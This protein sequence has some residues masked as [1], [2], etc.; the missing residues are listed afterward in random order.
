[1][2][3]QSIL[4][5]LVPP[6]FLLALLAAGLG[7]FDPTPGEAY[8]YTNFRGEAVMINNRGLYQFDTVSS[9]AQMQG[10]DLVT[11]VVALPLLAVSAW[12]AFRG[13]LRGQL[14]LT[15][16]I[17][18]ILYTYLSMSMLT[19]FNPLFLVY[20]ALF[21]LSLFSFIIC[22]LSF[23]LASLPMH[24]KPN[25]PVGWIAGFLFLVAGF[26]SLAW[27]GRAL[28]P[29]LQNLP[30]ALDN[31]T[32]M[33]IQA[34]DLGMIM[35]MAVLAGVLLLRRSALGYLLASVFITKAIT[36]G[37]AISAMVA[38][39]IRAGTPEAAG[40]AIPFL[41]ITAAAMIMAVVLLRNVREQPAAA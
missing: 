35:P 30:P 22:L 11:L 41:V 31:G 33:V 8:A 19:A 20:V 40:I 27:L 24:F 4:K 34:M 15:G 5:W 39:M 28:T 18:Y 38:N 10:N 6:I 25:L 16:A 14:L 7:L 2:K 23:D 1:M 9:A 37:L 3:Y 29:Y 32:T 36:L 26:L 13:S 17:G 12:L 21:S